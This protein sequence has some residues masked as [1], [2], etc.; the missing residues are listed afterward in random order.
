M[1]LWQDDAEYEP[2][3]AAP[4]SDTRH[5]LE[6]GALPWRYERRS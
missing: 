5:R 4:A 2:D 3:A 1:L 6:I